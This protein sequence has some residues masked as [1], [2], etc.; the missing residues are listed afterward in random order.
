[1]PGS[2]GCSLRLRPISSCCNW[3]VKTGG[4]PTRRASRSRRLSSISPEG[5]IAPPPDEPKQPRSST[6]PARPPIGRARRKRG[7]VS[8]VAISKPPAD[9]IGK[10][11]NPSTWPNS[12][13]MTRCWPS[14]RGCATTR[15]RNERFGAQWHGLG[16]AAA[17]RVV[18]ILVGPRAAIWSIGHYRPAA[19]FLGV[20]PE[21]PR[22]QTALAKRKPRRLQ[23]PRPRLKRG[24]G[25][26]RLARKPASR[27]E[28]ATEPPRGPRD[29][30]MARDRLRGA[31]GDRSRRRPR[32]SRKPADRALRAATPGGGGDDRTASRQPVRLN[33]LIDQYQSSGP[34]LR[35][36]DPTTAGGRGSSARSARSS[37][38][39]VPTGRR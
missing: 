32:L 9:A 25:Q 1:M 34:Q 33:D 18:L 4:N 28:N 27:V 7:D 39:T 20:A 22:P 10:A 11:G 38:S 6:P 23:P 37:R 5:G 21:P 36:G 19:R 14:R 31:A 8:I 16:S 24:R 2:T 29:A 26:D 17:G 3:R 15:L 13:R 12:R 30:P 35:S